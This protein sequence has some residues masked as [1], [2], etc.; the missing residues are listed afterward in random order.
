MVLLESDLESQFRVPAGEKDK[1][2]KQDVYDWLCDVR[3]QKQKKQSKVMEDNLLNAME[4]DTATHKYFDR[5][6]ACDAVE[7]RKEFE[8]LYH[9]MKKPP[10]PSSLVLD[11]AF[12]IDCT[13]SM[14]PYSKCITSTCESLISGQSSILEKLKST[15]PEIGFKLRVAILGFRDIDDKLKQFQDNVWGGGGHF[16]DN[17][18]DV[19]PRLKSMTSNTFCGGADI[20]EDHIGAIHHC[21]T[22]WNHSTDWTSDIKCLMLLSDAPSHGLTVSSL[23]G[24]TNYDNYPTRHPAGLSLNDAISSLLSR[25]I[26]LFF[27]SFNPNATARTEEEIQ[28]GMKAHPDNKCERGITCIPMVPKDQIQENGSGHGRHIIFVLDES[29]SMSNSWSGVVEAYAKYIQKRKQSQS[30]LDLVSVVQFNGGSRVTVRLKSLLASPQQLSFGGGGTQFHPAALEACKLARD[31]PP[32]HVPTIVFMSDGGTND[33]ASAARE[34]TLLNGH[35][36]QQSG[37][38]LE[39]HVIAFGS[40]AD[41]LQL[42]QIA[43]ASPVGKVHASANTADLASVFVSIASNQNVATLL[44]SEIAKRM[45]AAVS[46]KLSLEYFGS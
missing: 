35:V 41:T 40:G 2:P 12:A 14:A 32:T 42:Q 9:L 23:S 10:M 8:N 25:D 31:T 4:K 38:N 46:D 11:L 15:F 18:A 34:F 45:S 29:G 19:L 43:G 21:S 37:D 33:A 20:A 16:T 27:C 36:S 30:D 1:I 28:K 6:L 39:L 26:D 7:A 44:E 5:L 22:N 17:V 24:A 3:L 13:G